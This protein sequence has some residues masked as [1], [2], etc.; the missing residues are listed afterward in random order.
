MEDSGWVVKDSSTICCGSWE[1]DKDSKKRKKKGSLMCCNGPCCSGRGKR[2]VV[3]SW[4][5]F[6]LAAKCHTLSAEV[7]W[8]GS[9][10]CHDP[11][12]SF[13]GIF[14][15]LCWSITSVPLQQHSS[16]SLIF[17][18]HVSQQCFSPCHSN[19]PYST[20]SLE[21]TCSSLEQAVPRGITVGSGVR[22]VKMSS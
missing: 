22:V 18:P 15:S 5:H 21:Q 8:C 6:C 4:L 13:P 20:N 1:G 2:T 11:T 16:R 9:S 7:K 10:W 3:G 12:S 19:L 17:I 14:L